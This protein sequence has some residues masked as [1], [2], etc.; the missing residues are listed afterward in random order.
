MR[1][2]TVAL[3][4]MIA[5][6]WSGAG[7]ASAHPPTTTT[8]P[9]PATS[10]APAVTST[11]PAAATPSTM[12]AR[13]SDW[14]VAA[15]PAEPA[16]MAQ[17][18]EVMPV[19]AEMEPGHDWLPW[20]ALGALGLYLVLLWR[21][22]SAAVGRR[23]VP[24]VLLSV[25]LAYAGWV[26][27]SEIPPHGAEAWHLGAA[28]FLMAVAQFAMAPAVLTR[29]TRPLFRAVFWV[30]LALVGLYFFVRL[31]PQGPPLPW[32]DA[33]LW[34][35]DPFLPQEYTLVAV[36]VII[37]IMAFAWLRLDK[38]RLPLA[39]LSAIPIPHRVTQPV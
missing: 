14:N 7:Q 26:H 32:T 39:K 9:P 34:H 31:A 27:C 16:T 12:T 37:L 5:I 19:E 29:P 25:L 22:R 13:D 33:Y 2:L 8:A 11:A 1:R 35:Q 18:A 20:V 21:H 24:G 6:L 38:Y 28:F 17:P 30:N 4:L 23:L 10:T 15:R 3:S 36:E